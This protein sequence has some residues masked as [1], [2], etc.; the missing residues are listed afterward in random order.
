[1]APPDCSLTNLYCRNPDGND[2]CN[3][4]GS[5]SQSH[6]YMRLYSSPCHTLR[7]RNCLNHTQGNLHT[8]S[9]HHSPPPHW[10]MVSLTCICCYDNLFVNPLQ[11][12]SNLYHHG[13]T[14]FVLHRLGIGIHQRHMHSRYMYH[15][16]I[17]I[18]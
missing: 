1:M 15:C 9:R 7:L 2:C 17:S 5:G 8:L 11:H 10:G 13:V 12:W 4:L 14:M 6:L 16:I 3:I 18:F